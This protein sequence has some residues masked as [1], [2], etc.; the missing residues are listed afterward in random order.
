MPDVNLLA[1]LLA[2]IA[3]F[4]SGATYYALFGEQ[5]AEV[6]DAAASDEQPP[7]WKLAVIH[8]GDWLVKLPVVAVIVTVWQ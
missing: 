3:A 2:T 6:S 4:V 5:L 1:V 7:P 8:G